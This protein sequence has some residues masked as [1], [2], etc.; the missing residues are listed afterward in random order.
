MLGKCLESRH[1]GQLVT[2]KVIQL[3]VLLICVHPVLCNEIFMPLAF[4][5]RPEDFELVSFFNLACIFIEASLQFEELNQRL[6]RLCI[7]AILSANFNDF[8]NQAMES[9]EEVRLQASVS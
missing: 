9:L 3:A 8:L 5:M 4:S 6:D 7:C 2:K 1:C